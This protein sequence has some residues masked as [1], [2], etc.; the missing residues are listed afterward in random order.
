MN[1]D[2]YVVSEKSDFTTIGSRA[3]PVRTTIKL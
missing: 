3:K 2:I 1:R